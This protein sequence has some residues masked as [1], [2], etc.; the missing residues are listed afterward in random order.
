MNKS[1]LVLAINA[2][3]IFVM[4][5]ISVGVMIKWRK[6]EAKAEIQNEL[7]NY[8]EPLDGVE[9]TAG[10]LTDD[11][12]T[13]ETSIQLKPMSFYVKPKIPSLPRLFPSTPLITTNSTIADL[14]EESNGLFTILFKLDDEN[15]V[16]R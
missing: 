14:H 2:V 16:S 8:V 7:F 15:E 13:S 6:N 4:M 12:S 5:I 11:I 1:I 10:D 3:I 9:E